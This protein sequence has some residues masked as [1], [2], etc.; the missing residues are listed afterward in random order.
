M[1]QN[2]KDEPLY[3]TWA[4]MISRCRHSSEGYVPHVNWKHYGGRRIRVCDRWKHGED[5]VEG[6]YLWKQDMGPRPEGLTLDR[7]DPDGHYEPANCRWATRSVQGGNKSKNFYAHFTAEERAQIEA[8]EE[9]ERRK[10][11]EALGAF[12]DK[13]NCD[14]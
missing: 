7:I 4:N 8:Y 12:L 13:H 3:G 1:V 10:N 6:F 2:V 11:A 5:G 14:W 9:E